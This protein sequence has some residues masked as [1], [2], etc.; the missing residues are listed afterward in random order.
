VGDRRELDMGEGM[1]EWQECKL[2]DQINL[3]RG[4]DLPNRLRQDGNIPIYWPIQI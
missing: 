2:G 3:K 4:Y 1:S